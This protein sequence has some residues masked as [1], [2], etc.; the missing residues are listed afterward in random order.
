MEMIPQAAK[1]KLAQFVDVFC[2]KG[3][4]SPEETEQIF[5]AAKN[6]GLSVRAHMGQLSETSLTPFLRFHPA[7]F[8]HMDHVND[9]DIS[10]TGQTRYDRDPG[11]GSKL[12]SGPEEI[13]GCA[14]IDRQ[15]R[16]SRAGHGLQS[17]HVA[18]DQH[19][20][21][22]VTG[23]HAHE[24][25][26]GGGRCSGD[27]QWSMALRV[28][29]RKGSIEPGKDADLA[30]FDVKDYREIPYWFGSNHCAET[31]LNGEKVS[32]A[33]LLR[34]TD[35]YESSRSRSACYVL[36]VL[37][38]HSS[39]VKTRRTDIRSDPIRSPEET[40]MKRTLAVL[41]FLVLTIS[42]ASAQRLPEVARPENYKLTFTPDL[43][44][45][46][47]EGDETIRSVC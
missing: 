31:I 30:I 29:D 47:F 39:E 1:R 17:W 35:S 5:E 8:D 12:F 44:R 40:T 34:R 37:G 23:L 16:S 4:F 26:S 18:D 19:A 14:S 15:R 43:E 36:T 3:A 28:A 32:C 2:D 22:D 42:L 10:A 25:V 6:N 24:D 20:D 13:S 45:A 21:G 11:S 7:S 27:H 38:L 33:E 9:R 46:K 41:T